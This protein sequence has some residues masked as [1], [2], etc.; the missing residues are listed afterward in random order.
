MPA[1]WP[2]VGIRNKRGRHEL[3]KRKQ[4]GVADVRRYVEFDCD[5]HLRWLCRR[6]FLEVLP[7]RE[8]EEGARFSRRD[9][10]PPVEFLEGD[11]DVIGLAYYLQQW[12]RFHLQE[13]ITSRTKELEAKEGVYS[14]EAWNEQRAV[15]CGADERSNPFLEQIVNSEGNYRDDHGTSFGRCW[16]HAGA[17]GS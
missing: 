14:H 16:N 3:S 4:F 9:W 15:L 17:F 6:G 8:G 13:W 5:K 11:G 12:F 2:K 10:P 1:N 7:G